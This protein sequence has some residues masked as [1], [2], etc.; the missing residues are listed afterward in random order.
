MLNITNQVQMARLQDIPAEIRILILLSV[1]D[2]ETLKGA[3]L[4]CRRF[5]EAYLLAKRSIYLAFTRRK[6]EEDDL[7]DAIVAIRSKDLYIIIPSNKHNIL[8]LLDNRRRDAELQ[9]VY[10][11][12]VE[13]PNS[14]KRFKETGQLLQLKEETDFFLQEYATNAPIR[15]GC[16]LS[17]GPPI[18]NH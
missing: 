17:G 3:V 2:L 12:R 4:S 16:V 1:P 5:Y 9:R 14:P 8:A 10:S 18:R 6:L 7:A 13:S 11:S 15:K